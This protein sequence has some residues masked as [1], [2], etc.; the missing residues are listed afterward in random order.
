MA[1]FPTNKEIAEGLVPA[2]NRIGF[3]HNT[4]EIIKAEL[5]AGNIAVTQTSE[6]WRVCAT[7]FTYLT[8]MGAHSRCEPTGM[9]KQKIG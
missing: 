8:G 3:P 5:S 7:Q 9:K 2:I 6:F 1:R 4:F